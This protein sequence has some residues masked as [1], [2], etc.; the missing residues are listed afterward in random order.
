RDARGP[1]VLRAPED[2]SQQ[3]FWRWVHRH[4][5]WNLR[6][7]LR[8]DARGPHVLRAPEDF[9]QQDFWRWVHRHTSWN[10]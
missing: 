5:S 2:F 6:G 3:D 8:R 9:S 10:L 7:R 4:T 1:H